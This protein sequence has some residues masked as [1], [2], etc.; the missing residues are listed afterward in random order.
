MDVVR[1]SIERLKG[2][3]RI[4]SRDGAGCTLTFRLPVSLT[5]AQ[6]LFVEIGEGIYG[7]PSTTVDRVLYS[8]AGRVLPFGERY[9]FE[10]DGKVADLHSLAA[11]LGQAASDPS[12]LQSRPLPVVIANG[13]AGPVA[14][15]VDRA[16]DSRQIV[17]KGLSPL[18]PTL[19]GVS[20]ACVLPHGSIGVILEVRELLSQPAATHGISLPRPTLAARRTPRVLVVDDS[21]SARRTLAQ[22]LTDCGYEVATAVDGLDAI[23]RIDECRPDVVLADLEMPRMNGLELASHLRGRPGMKSLPIVMITS[24]AGDKHRSQALRAGVTEYLTK[25]YLEHELLDCLT[26][27]ISA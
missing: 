13:D 12:D 21:L 17:I 11:L 26:E 16:V 3:T 8:D 22:L 24:R 2:T 19:P 27:L 1:S 5:T 9:A 23:A 10:Y 25:P 4:E 20:G 7:L 15:L 6:V 18:L 14:L